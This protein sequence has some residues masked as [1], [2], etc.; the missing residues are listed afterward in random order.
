MLSNPTMPKPDELRE[1]D[2]MRLLSVIGS[3]S[4]RHKPIDHAEE[5]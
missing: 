5:V 4:L 1:E 3:A 2:F